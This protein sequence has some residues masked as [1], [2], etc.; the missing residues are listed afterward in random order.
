MLVAIAPRS[1]R[2]AV[3]LYVHQRRPHAEIMIV[4]PALLEAEVE[5]FRPH[6][7]VCNETIESVRDSVP[8]CVEILFE[9]S[10]GANVSVGELGTRKIEDIG[11]DDILGVIDVTEELLLSAT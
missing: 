1:Y 10:L 7:V 4:T 5:R 11:M 6:V 3:A 9:D 2:E 8:T